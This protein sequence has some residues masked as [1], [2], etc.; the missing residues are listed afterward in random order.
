MELLKVRRRTQV[1]KRGHKLL[2]DKLDELMKHF[3]ARIHQSKN[4]RR[5]MEEKLV[6]AYQLFA[7]ARAEAPEIVIEESLMMTCA[8]ATIEVGKKSAVNITIPQLKLNQ[9]GSFDC[10]SL[11]GTPA[12]L[13][14]GLRR[15]NELL[16]LMIELAEMERAIEL[17]SEEI[18]KT[19]RRVN[20]LEYIL[21]PQLDATV[22]FVTMKLD[23]MERSNLTRL[24]KIKSMVAEA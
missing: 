22:S 20:A 21:I 17:L 4:L 11:S 9:T 3:L 12:I 18:E 6:E 2:K 15:L 5:E 13:D 10:Y 16:P 24:M 23:E 7:I 1:A 19:R 8:E 14:E